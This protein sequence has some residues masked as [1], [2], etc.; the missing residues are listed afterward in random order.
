[1]VLRDA[2]A[3]KENKVLI[4]IYQLRKGRKI[5]KTERKSNFFSEAPPARQ[6][7]DPPGGADWRLEFSI[8]FITLKIQFRCVRKS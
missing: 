1:M 6:E 5:R 3:F 4:E 7:S 2:S 8:R